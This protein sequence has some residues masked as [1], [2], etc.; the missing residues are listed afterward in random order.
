MGRWF[1]QRIDKGRYIRLE[2]FCKITYLID[3]NKAR[4]RT[5][6]IAGKGKSPHAEAIRD[7]LY[8][9]YAEKA[10]LDAVLKE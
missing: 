8:D 6:Q 2:A 3:K 7:A 5:L 4:L 9:L 1:G 10:K